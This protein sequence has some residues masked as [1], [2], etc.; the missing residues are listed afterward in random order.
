MSRISV[1][2]EIGCILALSRNVC[3]YV[4]ASFCAFFNCFFCYYFGFATSAQVNA[5]EEG[6][7]I[8][9]ETL[10]AFSPQFGVW[11][12]ERFYDEWIKMPT[13][14]EELLALEKPFRMVGLPCTM[15]SQD[16]VHVEWD[17]CP[18][19]LRCALYCVHV[20][21]FRPFC[22]VSCILAGPTTEAKTI[23][24]I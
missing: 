18:A 10:Q 9:R 1:V 11:F 5:H 20:L 3:V 13:T 21:Q 22:F 15:C 19:A 14:T 6:S 24:P 23:T 4:Y 12:V 16:G 8:A 7:G 17:R 2:P